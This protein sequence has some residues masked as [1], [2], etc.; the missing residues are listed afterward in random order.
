M[1]AAAKGS[2]NPFYGKTHSEETRA[3]VSEAAKTWFKSNDTGFVVEV[4]DLENNITTEYRS[5]NE[6]ARSLNINVGSLLYWEKKIF[7]RN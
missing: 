7:Y 2:G 3:K 6:A 5:I 4:L 1:S